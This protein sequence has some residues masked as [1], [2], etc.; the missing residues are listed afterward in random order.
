MT[1]KFTAALAG[2]MLLA[3]PAFAWSGAPV[4]VHPYPSQHNYCPAGLQPVY[5]AGYVSCGVPNTREVY[6]DRSGHRRSGTYIAT[7]KGAG[8]GYIAYDKS[9]SD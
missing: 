2:A 6:S 1:L 7:G 8:D 3:A 4:L 5:V 9:P